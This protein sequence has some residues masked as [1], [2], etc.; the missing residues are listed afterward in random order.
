MA[1]EAE[2]GD[3]PLPQKQSRWCTR[4]GPQ[5]E[6]AER[7]ETAEALRSVQARLVAD[8]GTPVVAD[9]LSSLDAQRIE[10]TD[11]VLRE[12]VKAV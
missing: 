8:S 10:E 4:R 3:V 1:Q 5:R 6:A 7:E 12:A 11:Q 9:E 2:R